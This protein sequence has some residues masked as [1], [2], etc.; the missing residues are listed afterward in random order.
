MP[1]KDWLLEAA[2]E[3]GQQAALKQDSVCDICGLPLSDH[4]GGI[5]ARKAGF[6]LFAPGGNSRVIEK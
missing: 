4:Q 2:E 6:C 1:Y 3:A 5:Y